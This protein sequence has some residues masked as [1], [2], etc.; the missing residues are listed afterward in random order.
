MPARGSTQIRAVVTL[1]ARKNDGSL[2]VLGQTPFL[3]DAPAPRKWCQV[4]LI[5][6]LV[7]LAMR[8]ARADGKLHR[9]EIRKI[10][11]RMERL[12]ELDP[13]DQK[14][15]R[16]TMKSNK[17]WLSNHELLEA[18]HR[19]L[20]IIEMEHVLEV[21]VKV[22][23]CDGVVSPSEVDVIRELVIGYYGASPAKWA[24][25]E[26]ALGIEAIEAVVEVN[27][28]AVLSVSRGATRIEIKKAYHAKMRDYHPD[29]VANLPEE[30]Q[31][32]AHQKTIEIRAAYEAL[33][34]V[35]G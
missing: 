14:A 23:Q 16:E 17:P 26:R 29:K 2:I 21:L 25:A 30:F 1:A 4:E 27:H 32:L 9:Q 19:R 18:V 13:R 31:Q 34:K 28:W 22:A 20:P 6:P 33:L 12:F 35:V 11:D 24:E 15:L 7:L 5:E 10:R 8:V 3:M